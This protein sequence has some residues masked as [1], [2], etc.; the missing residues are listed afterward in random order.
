MQKIAPLNFTVFV[1]TF[2]NV[3]VFNK[4]HDMRIPI[5]IRRIALSKSDNQL[6]LLQASWQKPLRRRDEAPTDL[7]VVVEVDDNAIDDA[8]STVVR[9][10]STGGGG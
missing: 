8:P 10:G 3:Y 7:L 6:V 2:R 4:L 9:P 1:Q 5:G